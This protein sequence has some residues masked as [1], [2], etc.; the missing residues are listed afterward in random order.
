MTLAKLTLFA[1]VAASAL[2]QSSLKFEVATV[3]LADPNAAVRNQMLR[4]APN[5]MSIPSMTLI[6]LIYTA[7]GQGM[8]TSA[9]VTGAPDWANRTAY[10]VEGL[11]PEPATQRQFQE[12]LRSLLED[13]FAL[14]IR[15]ENRSGNVFALVLDRDG[16]LGPNVQPWDGARGTRPNGTNRPVQDAVG[17]Q[18]H[19]SATSRPG[20]APGQLTTLTSHGHPGTVGTETGT[21]AGAVHGLRGRERPSADG[22]LGRA[23]VDSSFR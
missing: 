19:C 21:G 3:K 13:R 11:A 4:P 2:A 22:E 23:S 18:V 16:K 8:N 14:K 15:T 5:R 10:A 6:W 12:M 1:W 7:Y 20:C 17:V 9:T